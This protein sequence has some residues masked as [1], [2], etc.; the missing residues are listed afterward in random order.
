MP[1]IELHSFTAELR[2]LVREAIWAGAFRPEFS[3]IVDEL[4]VTEC[5]GTE[6]KD[7]HNRFQPFV[8]VYYETKKELRIVK[9]ILARV[10]G[11]RKCFFDAEFIKLSHFCSFPPKS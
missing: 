7:R 6:T 8:R 11:L 10:P 3:E 2:P 9:K 5:L 4:V 1:N